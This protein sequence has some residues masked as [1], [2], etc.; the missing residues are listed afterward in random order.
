LEDLVTHF[1][2]FARIAALFLLVVAILGSYSS[3]E[4]AWC[5]N[6]NKCADT[7]FGDDYCYVNDSTVGWS[8]IIYGSECIQEPHLCGTAG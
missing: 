8:C 4:A 2:F 6:N 7:W 1:R 3:A 5:L